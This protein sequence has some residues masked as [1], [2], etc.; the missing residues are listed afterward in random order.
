[1]KILERSGDKYEVLD[2]VSRISDSV[3]ISRI[4]PFLY[5]DTR[6]PEKVAYRD[7]KE[8]EV[9]Q[10][11]DDTIDLVQCLYDFGGFTSNGVVTI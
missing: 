2:L 9:E 4:Y 11:L 7:R 8:F 10:I 6:V 1:M 3:V 5:D